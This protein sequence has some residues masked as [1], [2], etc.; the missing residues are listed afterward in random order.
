MAQLSHGDPK[1][2]YRGRLRS[3]EEAA[4]ML[5]PVDMLAVPIAAGQPVSFL[6]ALGAREFQDLLLFSGLV[7]QPYPLLQQPGVR[8]V[9]GFFGPIERMLRSAGIRVDYLPADFLGWERYALRAKPR[10]MASA[11]AP[12]DERGYLSFGLH[13]GATFHAFL[14]AARDPQRLA[15]AE[16]NRHIPRVHGIGRYG[17]HRIHV[18]E[19]DCVVESEQPIFELPEIP[20]SEE[21]KVIARHVESLIENGSTLQTGIGGVP[22]IVAQLLASGDK[23]DFGIHTEMLV[24]GVMHLHR[25]GK[26]TNHKGI[27][28]GFT[29][30]TF[31]LGSAELYRWVHDNPEVRMLPVT[32]VN[33]PGIIRRN[34]RMVS[35]NG[36]L[37]IDLSGQVMADSIGPTQYSGVGGHELFVMG[38]SA[39]VDG[40]SIICLHSTASVGGKPVSTI[41]PALPSGTPVSTPRH[42]VQYVVTEHGIA[43]L[44]MLTSRERRQ[45]LIG[46]AH[47]DFRPM[48]QD[49]EPK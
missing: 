37:A 19:V 20:V 16:V 18:S 41:L 31:A 27:F 49:A 23:G 10:V 11:V 44:G 25:A 4:A 2:L 17:G 6:N 24:D 3:L 1:A 36:A 22:N 38:A 39:C 9:S 15:I 47:P 34:R 26:V 48:L 40:K 30:S 14:E 13:S 35:I 45:A 7:I 43:D 42:H 29:I 33:D 12:M 46:I 28:D 21:D 8:L 32:E 5:R